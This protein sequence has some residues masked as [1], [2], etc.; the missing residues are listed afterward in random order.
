MTLTVNLNVSLV[1]HRI[2]LQF[3][4]QFIHYIYSS[5]KFACL[6]LNKLFWSNFTLVLTIIVYIVIERQ[7]ARSPLLSH[8]HVSLSRMYLVCAYECKFVSLH[9][10]TVMHFLI[11]RFIVYCIQSYDSLIVVV[12][13]YY[14]DGSFDVGRRVQTGSYKGRRCHVQHHKSPAAVG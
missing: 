12:W 4:V 6:F 2:Y 7:A 8:C 10:V 14:H 11:C 1:T 13:Y 5:L 3:L 9:C